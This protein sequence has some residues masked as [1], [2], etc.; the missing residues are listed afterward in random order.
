MSRPNL[1]RQIYGY[2]V[3]LIAI[4]TFLM[5]ANSVVGAIFDLN[6]PAGIADP[7]GPNPTFDEY[8]NDQL[9]ADRMQ[10]RQ[11]MQAGSP[12]PTAPV[13]VRPDSTLRREYDEMRAQRSANVHWNALKSIVTSVLMLVIALVLFFI[14][15]RWLRGLERREET[16]A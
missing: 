5:A 3:C 14:H 15:W 11:Q 4:I 16:H 12:A 1:I 6:R 8:R 2:L 13:Q 9:N 10:Q 7:Y